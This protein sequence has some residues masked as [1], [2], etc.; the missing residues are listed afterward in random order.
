M[1]G[2]APN[3]YDIKEMIEECKGRKELKNWLLK[4]EERVLKY[5]ED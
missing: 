4:V 1:Y 2:E 3:L 5:D